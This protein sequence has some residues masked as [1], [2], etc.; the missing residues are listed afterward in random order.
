MAGTRSTLQPHGLRSLRAYQLSRQ[1]AHLVYEASG[2][3]PRG[4]YRLVGQMRGA[5]VSVFGNIAEGYGRNA[6]GDY[7]RFCEIARGSLAEVGSYIEFCQE[8]DL[9]K[10]EASAE[11]QSRYNHCW[12]TLGALIRSLRTKKL[13][14]SWD[15]GQ[16]LRE[17]EDLYSV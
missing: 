8:R 2:K 9:V 16:A 4:E 6:I 11:L 1:L 3:F 10:G 15:R 12:N 7:I 17:N 13:D 5:A 14:G